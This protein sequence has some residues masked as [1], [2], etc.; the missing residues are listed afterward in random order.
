MKRFSLTLFVASALS[1]CASAQSLSGIS[2]GAGLVHNYFVLNDHS[3]ISF[4]NSCYLGPYIEAGYDWNVNKTNGIY[5]GVRYEFV[6]HYTGA[7]SYAPSPYYPFYVPVVAEAYT[8]RHYIDVPIKYRFVHR[9][10]TFCRFFF[11][12]GPTCNFMV[13]NVSRF[14]E[15]IPGFWSSQTVNWYDAAPNAY[16]WFNLSLGTN[17]GVILDHAKLFV[18]YDYGG[19]LSYTK[20]EYGRGQ[21]HQIRFGAAYMF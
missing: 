1:I 5:M 20:P 12:L 11:D 13:G 17:I 16:N 21:V 6:Q 4:D 2:L 7:G 3:N 8:Y 19:I 14:S 9:F 18:G 10:N 15:I